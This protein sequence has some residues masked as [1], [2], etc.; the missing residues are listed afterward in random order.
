MSSFFLAASL[1]SGGVVYAAGL[2]YFWGKGCFEWG[3]DIL[4]FGVESF[5]G[6]DTVLAQFRR[7]VLSPGPAATLGDSVGIG[8]G[9]AAFLSQR[10][11]SPDRLV[12]SAISPT[13][14]YVV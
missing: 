12:A 8:F 7:N 5:F 4:F 2:W 11:L 14:A 6:V 9:M 1:V 3:M 13:D 10:A